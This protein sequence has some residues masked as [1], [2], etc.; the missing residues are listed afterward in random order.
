MFFTSN[1]D[2]NRK[3]QHPVCMFLFVPVTHL[4]TGK[5][6]LALELC[7]LLREHLSPVTFIVAS[8]FSLSLSLF[9]L[10]TFFTSHSLP[11]SFPIFVSV[12]F[13]ILLLFQV[14]V[15]PP[16]DLIQSPLIFKP[17]SPLSL[18]LSLSLVLLLLISLF[19][20]VSSFPYIHFSYGTSHSAQYLEIE[21]FCSFLSC[22]F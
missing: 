8:N 6:F 5:S 12:S 9:T 16:L 17:H 1:R 20:H 21:F 13:S 14:K 10:I 7:V 15:R 11:F 19:F 3:Y 4:E 22:N 2:R 18:S